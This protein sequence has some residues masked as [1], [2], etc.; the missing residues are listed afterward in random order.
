MDASERLD[1]PPPDGDI[2]VDVAIV[3]AGLTGLWTAYYLARADP[4]LRIAVLDRH[5]VGFGASGRNGGWCSG[6]LANS[7]TTLADRHGRPATI[8][9]QAVMHDSVDEVGRVLAAEGIDADFTKGGTVTAAR[10]PEQHGRL[11]E[12]L[13]EARSFGL[14]TDDVRWLEPDEVRERCAMSA[15]RGS[16][17]HPP[18]R[19]G[20]PAAAG[21]RPGAGGPAAGG[22]DPRVDTRP[23]ADRNG[24]RHPARAS[25]GGRRRV[26]HRGVDG[27]APRCPSRS[28]AAVLADGRHGA[29]DRGAVGGHRPRR[30]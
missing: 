18:L 26:G 1:A 16:A 30:A 8:A 4:Q 10:T 3:G 28:R 13:L 25:A 5:H 9:M 11:F 6:L 29:A 19:R 15:T 14:T 17:V 21:P 22:G 24:A 12:E 20:A 23:R 27:D 7:L 2:S